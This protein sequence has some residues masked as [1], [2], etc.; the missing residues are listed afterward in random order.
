M[1]QSYF[2]S[3]HLKQRTKR[4]YKEKIEEHP[5]DMHQDLK[6]NRRK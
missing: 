1:I 4:N 2:N 6:K 3:Q 5:T